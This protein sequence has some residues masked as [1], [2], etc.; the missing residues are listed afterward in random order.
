MN[1]EKNTLVK[2]YT[3][4]FVKVTKNSKFVGCKWI[5]KMT[6]RNILG[7]EVV[8]VQFVDITKKLMWFDALIIKNGL[9]RRIILRNMWGYQGLL[10][11]VEINAWIKVQARLGHDQFS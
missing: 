4:K 5:F 2:N 9:W 6:K 8:M 7:V 11:Q 10:M 3:K 1:E